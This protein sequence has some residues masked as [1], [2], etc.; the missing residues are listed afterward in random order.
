MPLNLSDA[1]P[2]L[3]IYPI[4]ISRV[5]SR[6]GPPSLLHKSP[7][8]LQPLPIR[9]HAIDFLAVV[10]RYRVAQRLCARIRTE[11][12]NALVECTLFL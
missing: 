3:F 2:L 7:L 6:L 8:I 1:T 10:I 9:L 11:A 12:F 5:P 4:D